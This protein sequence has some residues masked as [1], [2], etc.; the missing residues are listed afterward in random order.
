MEASQLVASE[1]FLIMFPLGVNK[2]LGMIEIKRIKNISI[3]THF[4]IYFST[5][6]I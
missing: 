5:N 1:L 6:G 3:I 4:L 2:A